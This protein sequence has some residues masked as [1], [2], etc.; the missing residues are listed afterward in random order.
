MNSIVA[1]KFKTNIPLEVFIVDDHEL[2]CLGI[3]KAINESKRFNFSGYALSSIKALVEIPLVK[4]DI[5]L[6]DC[7]LGGSNELSGLGLIKKLHDMLPDTEI[8]A[9]S[10]WMDTFF[11]QEAEHLGASGVM[12][13]T[14]RLDEV[15]PTLLKIIRSDEFYCTVEPVSGKHTFGSESLLSS[16]NRREKQ[17]F[18]YLAQGATIKDIA[19]EMDVSQSTV[20][21]HQKRLMQKLKIYCP[22]KLIAFASRMNGLTV[23]ARAERAPEF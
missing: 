22:R 7:F 18:S 2:F 13:S 8:V 3:E 5:V 16:L 17:L 19:C 9:L 12:L 20:N 23:C 11:I 6:I 21:T 4:P 14:I 10:A 1:A 15:E